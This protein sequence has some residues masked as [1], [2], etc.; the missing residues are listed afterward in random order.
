MKFLAAF[1]ATLSLAS[2]FAPVSN[3]GRVSTEV[4]ALFDAVS[5]FEECLPVAPEE[6]K[7]ASALISF[8]VSLFDDI[9]LFLAMQ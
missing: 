3:K 9:L 8:F 2:A 7:R 4:N 1:V 6:P 5:D